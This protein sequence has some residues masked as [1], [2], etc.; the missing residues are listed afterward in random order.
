V[1]AAREMLA[2]IEL[3]RAELQA[4]NE[5][6]ATFDALY[7]EAQGWNREWSQRC[8]KAEA[9]LAA[10]RERLS[11]ATHFAHGEA[12]VIRCEGHRLPKS[13]MW[14]VEHCGF[15]LAKDGLWECE[16]I[17]SS[18]NVEYYQRCR[19]DTYE[20]AVVALDAAMRPTEEESRG[21]ET[22][23]GEACD[24]NGRIFPDV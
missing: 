8:E 24:G 18:R 12:Y 23:D 20:D 21:Y 6:A 5:R 3:L 22:V 16:P 2:E 9:D 11:R 14:K 17:P 15:A 1:S 13:P 4:A 10:A 19:Y 7:L